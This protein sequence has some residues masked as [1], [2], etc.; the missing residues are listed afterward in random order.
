MEA[1]LPN[2]SP[3]NSS[4][5]LNENSEMQTNEISNRRKFTFTLNTGDLFEP[6]YFVRDKSQLS[7]TE[8]N[9]IK[10]YLGA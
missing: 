1:R 8:Y 6:I 2:F 3:L 7:L 10:A 5:Q 4:D 9:K